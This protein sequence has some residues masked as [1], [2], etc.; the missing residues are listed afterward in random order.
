MTDLNEYDYGINFDNQSVLINNNDEIVQLKSNEIINPFFV[1]INNYNSKDTKYINL[2]KQYK[3]VYVLCMSNSYNNEIEM[4]QIYDYITTIDKL[5]NISKYFSLIKTSLELL[6]INKHF[7]NIIIVQSKYLKIIQSNNSDIFDL[8]EIVIPIFEIKY[9]SFIS[10]MQ[11]FDKNISLSDIQNKISLVNY[12]MPSN[13]FLITNQLKNIYNNINGSKYWINKYR[14]SMNVTNAFNNRCFYRHNSN[15]NFVNIKNNI[16][17]PSSNNIKKINYVNNNDNINNGN[18]NYLESI[19]SYNK[20]D[21]SPILNN[22]NTLHKRTYYTTIDNDNITCQDINKLIDT[23]TDEHELYSLVN[24]LITS[25]DYCHLILNNIYALTKLSSLFE[26]YKLAFRYTIGYAWLCFYIEESILKTKTTTNNRY[27]FDIHTAN[28]LPIFPLCY[29]NPKINPYLT[30]LIDDNSLNLKNNCLSINPINDESYY[31]VCTLDEFK[32]RLNIFTSRNHNI[33]IFNGIDWNKFAISG[34]VITACLQKKSPLINLIQPSTLSESDKWLSYFDT[35]YK[36]SDIDLMCN[37][38]CIFSFV[39]QSKNIYDIVKQNIQCSDNEFIVTSIKSLNI[40]ITNYFFDTHLNLFNQKYGTSLDEI[41]FK[42]EINSIQFKEYIYDIYYYNKVKNNN[43]FINNNIMSNETIFEQSYYNINNSDD[44]TI[45]YLNN[46]NVNSFKYKQPNHIVCLYIND[47]RDENNKVPEIDNYLIL[48]ISESIRFKYSINTQSIH[49]TFELFRTYNNNFF[50][51]VARFHLPCVR[52]YYQGNNVYML[53]SC[54]TAMMTKINIEY[55]Y[56]AAIHDP[57][58]IINKYITRGY[59]ILLNNNELK[60]WIDFNKKH[61]INKFYD[62]DIITGGKNI[63]HPIFQLSNLPNTSID[64]LPY[65][66]SYI[67][68]EHYYNKIPI[69]CIDLLKLQTISPSGIIQPYIPSAIE[70]YYE[71]T[72]ST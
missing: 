65:F 69:I 47:Y 33:D 18:N 24:A 61:K 30:L 38:Q 68:V 46:F 1:D 6:K 21:M 57:F 25:K 66:T 16:I 13:K 22:V 52:A 5:E 67:D 3:Y 12:F 71:L 53:P 43:D 62:S 28:K 60:N 35:Y 42:N 36:T 31:G 34:S 17:L 14:C 70:L 50:S 19:N 27:V 48:Q 54:I 56:F 55:R 72:N 64:I 37:E 9:D 7:K 32:W 23:H 63:S 59:G 8:T 4:T 20:M 40:S 10:Y 45:H 39:K 51:T 58:D 44:M 15:G 41:S 2:Y 11:L 26:K 49:K 29:E